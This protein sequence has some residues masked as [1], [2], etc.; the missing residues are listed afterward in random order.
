M[1]TILKYLHFAFHSRQNINKLKYKLFHLHPSKFLGDNPKAKQIE[2][3]KL[4]T[5]TKDVYK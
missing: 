1:V 3:F 4:I 2:A 5:H